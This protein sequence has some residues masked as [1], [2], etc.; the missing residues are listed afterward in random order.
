ME[1]SRKT[2]FDQFAIFIHRKWLFIVPLIIGSVAGLAV[3]FELPEKYSSTTLI[4]VEEQQIPEEYVTPTDKT[5]FSQRLNV[6]SQQILSRTRLEKIIKEFGL[7]SQQGPG[8]VDKAKSLITGSATEAPTPDEIIEQ[9]RADIQFTVIGEQNPKKQQGSGGN[10]FSITYS[11]EDPQTTMQVTNTLSSLFIEENLKVREQYAEGT[12]EFLSSELET[13]QQELSVLEQ[14]LKDFKQAHMGTLPGQ[15]DANLRTL[16]RLQL[17]LQTVSAQLK[18]NEDRKLVLDEQMKYNAPM[19]VSPAVQGSL[20]AELE[21]ARAELG[22][23]LSVYKESYPDVIILRKRIKDLERQVQGEVVEEPAKGPAPPKVMHPAYSELMAVKSQIT[24][25]TRREANIRKQ[26]DQYSSRVELTPASEQQLSDLQRDYD[27]S[28]QNYQAL[29][30][31]KMSARLSE[32]LEKRQKGARFRVVDPANVPQSPD[33][34]NK[35]LVITIGTLAG[36]AVGIG[37]VFLV[38][39]MNPAFRKPEDFEGV[40]DSPVLTSIPLFSLGEAVKK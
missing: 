32:N 26:I 9:M 14:K 34:P 22:Q 35:P 13:A 24:T 15:L 31:K 37:L 12:S 2:I 7:Y 5:P 8:L 21:G 29:L 16:D 19:A 33:Q 36:A 18:T 39:F 10:A 27:I 20:A 11:G 6:I 1:E 4:L 30:E 25:L 28:L 3:S 17:E 38:E 23:M 40:I